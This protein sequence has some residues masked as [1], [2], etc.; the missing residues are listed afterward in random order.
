M[1]SP[2]LFLD[3]ACPSTDRD[4]RSL[5]NELLCIG[6]GELVGHLRLDGFFPLLWRHVLEAASRSSQRREV[7]LV[8]MRWSVKR[9]E[10]LSVRSSASF[11]R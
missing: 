8:D 6:H 1:R 4:S 9:E 2:L 10:V 5:F 11:E 7:H 3:A